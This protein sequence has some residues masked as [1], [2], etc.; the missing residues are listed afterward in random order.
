MDGFM[1]DLVVFVGRRVGRAKEFTA[2]LDMPEATYAGLS[3]DEKINARES[4]ER[5]AIYIQGLA[6][7]L[8]LAA[9]ICKKVGG[10]V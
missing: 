5:D 3:D 9:L 4:V 2:I 7:G 8:R 10:H 1:K 6:D